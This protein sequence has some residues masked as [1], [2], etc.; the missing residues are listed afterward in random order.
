MFLHDPY[1]NQHSTVWWNRFSKHG[2]LG[3]ATDLMLLKESD[4]FIG[5]YSSNV[6]EILNLF[7]LA[8]PFLESPKFILNRKLL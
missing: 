6:S 5:T 4:F 1:I 3:V 8:K 2:V 7:L